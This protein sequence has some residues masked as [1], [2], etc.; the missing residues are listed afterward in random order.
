MLWVVPV[1]AL[2][3]CVAALW[4]AAHSGEEGTV[5]LALGNLFLW[6]GSNLCWLGNNLWALPLLDLFVG[7]IALFLR[8]VAAGTWLHLYTQLVAARLVLHV[9]QALT[10]HLF[11]VPYIHALNA[12]FAGMLVAVA[13]P[14]G[15]NG[16]HRLLRRLRFLGR[17]VSPAPQRGLSGGR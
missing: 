1:L 14:G 16:S 5:T 6:A 3:G 12:T 13:Y 7:G 15:R 4:F 10:G 17:M 2:A 8:W 9:I 11:T